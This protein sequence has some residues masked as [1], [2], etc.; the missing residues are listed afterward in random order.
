MI[1]QLIYGKLPFDGRKQGGGIF[2][3]TAAV[4]Q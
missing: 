3:L 2:G 1:Y 4:L